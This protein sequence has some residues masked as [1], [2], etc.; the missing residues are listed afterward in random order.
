MDPYII[1]GLV[2]G[3]IGGGIA[4]LVIALSARKSCPRCSAPLPK[5]RLPANLRQALLGG[6][7][8]GSCGARVG[9]DGEVV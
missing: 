4:A 6:W 7:V 3:L 8:C 9:R 2:S 5:F 1:P